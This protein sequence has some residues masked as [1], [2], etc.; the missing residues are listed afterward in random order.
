MNLTEIKDSIRSIEY[1]FLE[2][3][4][5][6]ARILFF[7]VLSEITFMEQATKIQISTFVA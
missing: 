7:L 4:R 3:M 1:G 5:I 6:L 2:K